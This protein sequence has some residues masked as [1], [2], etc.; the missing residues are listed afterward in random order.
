MIPKGKWPLYSGTQVQKTF[1]SLTLIELHN[2]ILYIKGWALYAEYLG[3]EMN[4]YEDDY[5]Q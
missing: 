5:E 2:G 4:L 3:E 1:I